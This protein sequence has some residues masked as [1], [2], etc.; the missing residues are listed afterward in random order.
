MFSN[1]PKKCFLRCYACTDDFID[2]VNED[3]DD[4]TDVVFFSSSKALYINH[5][6][7]IPC[8]TT[9]R[10]FIEFF[11]PEEIEMKNP[12]VYGIFKSTIILIN[13]YNR[14]DYAD[15]E[16]IYFLS[17]NDKLQLRF[18]RRIDLTLSSTYPIEMYWFYDLIIIQ[19]IGKMFLRASGNMAIVIDLRRF[20]VSQILEYVSPVSDVMFFKWSKQDRMINMKVEAKCPTS[21]TYQPCYLRY[22]VFNGMTLKNLALNIVAESFSLEKIQSSNLPHSLVQEILIGKMY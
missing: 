4:Y 20:Q 19:E 8:E 2:D 17:Y 13:D 3:G 12:L 7:L 22:S 14:N 16:F 10:N 1:L 5:D 6:S 15:T 21:N 9:E 11:K 18:C